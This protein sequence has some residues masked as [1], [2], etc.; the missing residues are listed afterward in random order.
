LD[1]SLFLKKEFCSQAQN[2]L[3]V[4]VT[5]AVLNIAIYLHQSLI[6]LQAGVTM[7]V[8]KEHVLTHTALHKNGNAK[9]NCERVGD[10]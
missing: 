9:R 3:A 7:P 4:S 10:E 8:S 2:K 5:K 1:W 6:G